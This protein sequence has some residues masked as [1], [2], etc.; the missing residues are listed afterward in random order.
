MREYSW[1]IILE[2]LLVDKDLIQASIRKCIKSTAWL[3]LLHH[4]SSCHD[5]TT[6]ISFAPSAVILNYTEQDGLNGEKYRKG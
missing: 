4:V 6:D 2:I 5:T 1:L 3:G